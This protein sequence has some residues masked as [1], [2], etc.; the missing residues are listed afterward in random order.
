MHSTA[1]DDANSLAEM[2]AA[3]KERGYEYIG[4]TDHSQLLK[5]TNGLSES[6]HGDLS[7]QGGLTRLWRIERP[8]GRARGILGCESHADRSDRGFFCLIV[9]DEIEFQAK[10]LTQLLGN[11]PPQE[12]LQKLHKSLQWLLDGGLDPSSVRTIE[13]RV[14]EQLGLPITDP[15]ERLPHIFVNCVQQGAQGVKL[16]FMSRT[17]SEELVQAQAETI[18]KRL[19]Q[20]GCEV[21]ETVYAPNPNEQFFWFR[22]KERAGLPTFGNSWRAMTT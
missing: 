17:G 2:A 13:L 20:R 9:M 7:E 11:L 4:I 1:S 12:R 10:S 15:L 18:R 14:C 8:P 5:I 21:S 6:G 16:G 3:G 22:V 19:E